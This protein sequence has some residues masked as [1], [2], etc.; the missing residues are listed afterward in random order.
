[1][2]TNEAAC[3]LCGS[4]LLEP[5][6]H[7]ECFTLNKNHPY[8]RFAGSTV[9]KACLAEYDNIVHFLEFY[10]KALSDA[11]LSSEW[12]FVPVGDEFNDHFDSQC[13]QQPIPD[14]PARDVVATL[15]D[16]D[17]IR[18]IERDSFNCELLWES[19]DEAI[20]Y[21]MNTTGV[22]EGASIAA[23][24]MPETLIRHWTHL[25]NT[26]DR[27]FLHNQDCSIFDIE[28]FSSVYSNPDLV[29]FRDEIVNE[30]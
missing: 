22:W 10:F 16:L 6:F 14:Y 23:S 2:H 26:F 24:C 13:C 18:K 19:S 7:F 11:F 27:V 15:L 21:R 5:S 8:F 17:G 12:S 20:E 29:Q 1:M 30:T 9:H 25:Q 4:V 28:Y 3:A